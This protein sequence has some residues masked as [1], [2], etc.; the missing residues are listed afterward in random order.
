MSARQPRHPGRM[1]GTPCCPYCRLGLGQSETIMGHD[2]PRALRQQA[3]HTTAH[4]T[5]AHIELKKCLCRMQEPSTHDIQDPPIC[6]AGQVP[7]TSPL[8]PLRSISLLHTSHFLADNTS[9]NCDATSALGLT[10]RIVDVEFDDFPLGAVPA[11]DLKQNSILT[12]P[13]EIRP[14]RC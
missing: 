8:V 6:R 10:L 13:P 11:K 9:S 12:Q 14:Q 1:S 4:L 3:G 2:Q 5:N 7:Q